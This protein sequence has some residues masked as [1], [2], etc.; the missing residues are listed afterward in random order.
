MMLEAFGGIF[1]AQPGEVYALRQPA[2]AVEGRAGL[3]IENPGLIVL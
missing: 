3:T 1:E 2:T